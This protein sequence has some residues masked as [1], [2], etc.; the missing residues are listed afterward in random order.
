MR[1]ILRHNSESPERFP[2]A[3]FVIGSIVV[4]TFVF[5]I[6]L[7]VGRIV[8]RDR[9]GVAARNDEERKNY[10]IQREMSAYSEEAVKIPVV[11]PPPAPLDAVEELRESEK[12]VTFPDSLTRADAVPQPL[13]KPSESAP[14]PAPKLD[15]TAPKPADSSPKPDATTPKPVASTPKP[16]ATKPAASATK[17]AASKPVGATATEKSRRFVLQVSA[18]RNRESAESLKNKLDAK[19]FRTRLSSE[20]VGGRDLYKV[21]VGPYRTKEDA[22][23][24]V[25]DIKA[26]FKLDPIIV[27]E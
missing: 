1:T 13:V 18:L 21:R 27:L 9:I 20:T 23:K 17:P 2:N 4:F 22:N 24:A 3:F 10:D 19:G 26:A 14:K 25:K 15:A 16:D 8:E 7:Q 5:F 6:G 11:T 12:G